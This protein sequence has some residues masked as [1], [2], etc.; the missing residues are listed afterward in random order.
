MRHI[1]LIIGLGLLVAGP[2]LGLTHLS[3]TGA[4]QATPDANAWA[5][6]AQWR[7]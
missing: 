5:V 3:I 1:A 6:S 7:F 4:V 2:A